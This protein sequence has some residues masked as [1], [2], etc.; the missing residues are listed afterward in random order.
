MP[1]LNVSA[2]IGSFYDLLDPLPDAH[3]QGFTI[4]ADPTD[5]NARGI[6]FY[7]LSVSYQPTAAFAIAAGTETANAHLAPDSTYRAAFF[8]RNTTFF[9]SLRAFPAALL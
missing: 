3:T 2:Q 7:I 4:A 8:N 5:P 9:L 6:A 1:K